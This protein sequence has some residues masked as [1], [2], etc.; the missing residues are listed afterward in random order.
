MGA[1]LSVLAAL[2]AS[3]AAVSLGVGRFGGRRAAI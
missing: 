2:I 1:L 3:L